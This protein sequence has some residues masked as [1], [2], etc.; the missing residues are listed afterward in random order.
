MNQNQ[1]CVAPD[2][3]EDWALQAYVD[4]EPLPAVADHLRRCP[5]C[6][7]KAEALR[8]W[9]GRLAQRL[10]RFDCPTLD[11]LRAF[12]WR[13]LAPARRQPLADHLAV[14]LPCQD[15]V[16][17]LGRTLAAPP[18][19]ARI[20]ARPQ[21]VGLVGAV[22]AVWGRLVQPTWTPSLALRGLGQRQA[23]YQAGA[24]DVALTIE[25]SGDRHALLG[26][27]LGPETETGGQVLLC[28]LEGVEVARADLDETGSFAL[29]R[30]PPPPWEVHLRLAP[31]DREEEAHEI[32]LVTVGLEA[33]HA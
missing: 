19:A 1:T 2:E 17:A 3:I 7:A 33:A 27:A 5:A 10:H 12:V 11:D 15:E 30:L 13:A 4:G 16:A 20:E 21:P 28:D 8:R 29:T 32:V 22:R 9:E 14:C 31:S 24:T 18:F 23:I 25:T 26:Q 6:A